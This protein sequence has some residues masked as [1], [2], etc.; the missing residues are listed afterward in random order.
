MLGKTVPE[1]G[2]L[3]PPP[4]QPEPSQTL[5]AYLN[6]AH[7]VATCLPYVS[8]G[9]RVALS[10]LPPSWKRCPNPGQLG[11][12]GKGW[13]LPRFAQVFCVK[14]SRAYYHSSHNPLLGLNLLS[15]SDFQVGRGAVSSQAQGKKW[16]CRN[17]ASSALE[18]SSL[19]PSPRRLGPWCFGTTVD[20]WASG[21][22]LGNLSVRHVA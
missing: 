19:L 21:P 5:R 18:G 14:P 8:R 15:P 22:P 13:S 16:V 12:P 3:H 10:S 4:S 9:R 2:S 6:V 11:S 20:S 7:S 1:G 17:L